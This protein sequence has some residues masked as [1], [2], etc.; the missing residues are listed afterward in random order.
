MYDIRVHV[1]NEMIFFTCHFGWWHWFKWSGVWHV[2]H[3]LGLWLLILS[4]FIWSFM[5]PYQYVLRID[6]HT[7]TH[8]SLSLSLSLPFC[9]YMRIN[10][11]IYTHAF[12]YLLLISSHMIAI[13]DIICMLHV[14]CICNLATCPSPPWGRRSSG[15]A[16]RRGERLATTLGGSWLV[17][18]TM[19]MVTPVT[20]QKKG[21]RTPSPCSDMNKKHW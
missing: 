2:P 20:H 21:W 18:K 3:P 9:V 8:I 1:L 6:G 15:T 12:L 17:L 14:C 19:G 16:L 7:H 11:Y 5:S 10:I 13:C 4:L